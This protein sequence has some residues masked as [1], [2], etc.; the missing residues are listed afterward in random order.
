MTDEKKL[1]MQC[2][3][4]EVYFSAKSSLKLH[5]SSVHD[6]QK[7]YNCQL[8]NTKFNQKCNLKAHNESVHETKNLS[9]VTFVTTVVLRSIT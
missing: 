6:K 3:I 8:C 5:I 7:P 2:E 9:N 4:C 1:K